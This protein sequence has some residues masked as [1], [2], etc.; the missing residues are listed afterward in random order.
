VTGAPFQKLSIFFPMW[1]E[2]AYIHRAVG[3]AKHECEMLVE[4]GEILDYELIVVDDAS[5]DRTPELADELAANDPHVRVVHHPVNRKLGGS[6]KTGFAAATGDLAADSGRAGDRPTLDVLSARS[7]SALGADLAHGL[8][9]TISRSI[10]VDESC[11]TWFTHCLGRS[12]MIGQ[13]R[14]RWV[15][16]RCAV[17][18]AAVVL[19]GGL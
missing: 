2:E 3:Y 13:G 7:G 8:R 16:M 17:A 15:S 12:C 18:M 4:R 9:C 10:V 19:G 1:N 14:A 6:I 11:S 5:T